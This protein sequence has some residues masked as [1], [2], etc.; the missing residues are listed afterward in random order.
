MW[1]FVFIY[2]VYSKAFLSFVI[3][4]LTR[5]PHFFCHVKSFHL[6]IPSVCSDFAQKQSKQ[7]RNQKRRKEQTTQCQSSREW[8]LNF[9]LLKLVW[10]IACISSSNYDSFFFPL[11]CFTV[12][13]VKHQEMWAFHYVVKHSISFVIDTH[14]SELERT[15]EKQIKRSFIHGCN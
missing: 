13:V 7:I 4:V 9:R 6:T 3:L 5:L 1:Y 11:I 15:N 12:V 8:A 10:L 14:F 2:C